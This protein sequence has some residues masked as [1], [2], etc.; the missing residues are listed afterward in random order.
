LLEQESFVMLLGQNQEQI[1]FLSNLEIKLSV[2]GVQNAAAGLQEIIAHD[3]QLL[4]DI[5]KLVKAYGSV[6][7]ALEALV[8]RH[9]E[10]EKASSDASKTELTNQQRLLQGYASLKQE[11]KSY[12]REITNAAKKMV[13]PSS[14]GEAVS[15]T[16]EY[17]KS[18]LATSA[19]INRLG[20]GLGHL[21]SSLE[22]VSKET[23]LTRRETVALFNQYQEN[24]RFVSLS[25][26]ENMLKRIQTIVGA[27]SQEMGKMQASIAA[28]SQEYPALANGLANLDK[29]GNQLGATERSLLQ[30]RI[31]NLYFIGK[32]SDAQYKQVTSY[33]SGNQQ[34][35]GADKERQ[36]VMQAQ[37]ESAN[38]FK[39]QWETTTMTFGKELLPLLQD[40]ADI[41]RKIQDFTKGWELSVG[42]VVA[43]YAS[44]KIAGG[45][46]SALGSMGVQQGKGAIA[47]GFGKLFSKGKSGGGIASSVAS[48]AGSAAG[49]SLGGD[50]TR[51]FVTNWPLSLSPISSATGSG[52]SQSDFL[53]TAKGL[54]SKSKG[55]TRFGK[56]GKLA[57]G[58]GI[59]TF[60]SALGWG[61]DK[62]G[63]S[64]EESG[65]GNWGKASKGA[66]SALSIGGAAKT[67]AAI[68]SFILPG[69]GTAIGGLAG[70]AIGAASEWEDIKQLF[71][72]VSSSGKGPLADL[73]SEMDK[74]KSL[75]DRYQTSLDKGKQSDLA[76]MSASGISSV[77]EKLSGELLQARENFDKAREVVDKEIA[78]EFKDRGIVDIDV[79]LKGEKL[80]ESVQ[81]AI[82]D[83]KQ[84][85]QEMQTLIQDRT[86]A[87][88]GYG[89]SAAGKAQLKKDQKSLQTQKDKL[90][91]M[92]KI[93]E[94]EEK[95]N[96]ELNEELANRKAIEGRLENVTTL[97]AKQKDVAESLN[98][99]Y[100]AQSGK[101]DALV[102]KMSI[103]GD[104]DPTKAFAVADQ[105]ANILNQEM[106]ARSKV[107]NL[108]R[109]KG[110]VEAAQEAKRLANSK[111]ISEAEKAI[112]EEFNNLNLAGMAAADVKKTEIELATRLLEIEKE[113]TDIYGK[114]KGIVADTL[115]LTQA[116]ATGAGLLVQLAD[117]YAMGVGASAE[118]RRREWRA[119][120]EV[121]D[122]LKTR[123]A[124][125]QMSL[126]RTTEGSK[127]N[128]KIRTD[129]RNTENEILQA[130][131]KQAGIVRSM[132]DAWIS[133]ISAMNTGMEGFSEI[134]MS[135]E[136]NTA[137]IQ[138]LDGA[139]RSSAS[140]AL[141][142]RDSMGRII[143]DV[144]FQ[145]SERMNQMGDIAGRAGRKLSDIAYE[146][147][148]PV[149]HNTARAIEQAMRG[150]TSSMVDK[151]TQDSQKV[152]EGSMDALAAGANEITK[153]VQAGHDSF[154]KNVIDSSKQFSKN[155]S[156]SEG[157]NK[158]TPGSSKSMSSANA[159]PVFVVNFGDMAKRGGPGG[160]TEDSGGGTTTGGSSA[161]GEDSVTEVGKKIKKKE[162]ELQ[163]EL[164]NL[165]VPSGV[166]P[167]VARAVVENQEAAIN[168]SR[169]AKAELSQIQ[170]T[171]DRNT[172]QKEYIED[173]YFGKGRNKLG[174][175]EGITDFS[176]YGI[177]EI[178]GMFALNRR[179]GEEYKEKFV[180]RGKE[181]ERRLKELK[182]KYKHWS[183]ED[184]SSIK[185]V[186]EIRRS[187]E[188][189]YVSK[190]NMLAGALNQM[191]RSRGI[192]DRGFYTPDMMKDNYISQIM[193][194]YKNTAEDV[195]P[196]IQSL[197]SKII[198][199]SYIPGEKDQFIQSTFG[200]PT[201]LAEE[202]LK[203][204][205][206]RSS[207]YSGMKT[208]EGKERLRSY[209]TSYKDE[210]MAQKELV[211]TGGGEE[212]DKFMAMKEGYMTRKEMAMGKM[213]EGGA[214][215]AYAAMMEYEDSLSSS[216]A[217]VAA[218]TPTP[219]VETGPSVEQQ[220]LMGASN[221]T[222]AN[223]VLPNL[224]VNIGE[225]GN[226][227]EL[228]AILRKAVD[229][230]IR[231]ALGTI[232]TGVGDYNDPTNS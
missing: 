99:L 30:E 207:I 140:G 86:D 199:E 215:K 14:L 203:K 76:M 225:I 46:L 122:D 68:G 10:R 160:T 101:L 148:R 32:I 92:E 223:I 185:E 18:L 69:W 154:S 61:A 232:S 156:E 45:A 171:L 38:E 49:L 137:Q 17:N 39:R 210:L 53:N 124:I 93:V 13:V 24:M 167:T 110:N 54:V 226:V 227:G 121:I 175:R 134:I 183:P 36:R 8:K 170:E 84:Y 55:A 155:V 98:R 12:G 172:S 184:L 11:V 16:L 194:P 96:D 95:N 22:R 228:V 123:L 85:V 196:K 27:N 143:E 193:S 141:A 201:A 173:V 191:R 89:D 83:Q 180:E 116:Q 139:V 129:I 205:Q 25:Q 198:P 136:Q 217:A 224:S 2:S 216:K 71:G 187:P 115:Q 67:G 26:F 29:M 146:T 142:L 63:E 151:L 120:Q 97:M 131:I 186:A 135:A 231:N 211:K 70:G 15:T 114:M 229:N 75:K 48:V 21:T 108:I 103:T 150:Q 182:E 87:E 220:T 218:A 81:K 19:S 152:A 57:K 147:G 52:Q 117:N 107:L 65:H 169:K 222:T 42:K 213:K 72:G 62:L 149:G 3:Q 158:G 102:T 189:N 44:F 153:S 91:W 73:S 212:Y 60:L 174:H 100:S 5:P 113:R 106:S 111:D 43:G 219:G 138:Q 41:L 159:T 112:Y 33:I 125:E 4:S 80:R 9:K 90:E 20:V 35:I 214:V 94:N 59:G 195:K 179:G 163:E 88:D 162:E 144:G 6:D 197:K 66:G 157:L 132:K 119:Q 51:V 79:N 82:D 7:K 40:A 23:T 164:K 145:G 58:V 37:I 177:Q 133:A 28:V 50:G 78:Q 190:R 176:D 161:T 165:S 168:Q 204:K 192:F 104:V 47:K 221:V 178:E 208:R 31:R 64:L 128:K 181:K 188:Y 34:A 130:Q 1:D 109:T 118:L 166:G 202:H 74:E 230:G 126:D 200:D 206:M 56:L 77:Y 209:L 105:A 127:D